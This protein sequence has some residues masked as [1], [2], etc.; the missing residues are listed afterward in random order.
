MKLFAEYTILIFTFLVIFFLGRLFIAW[1]LSVSVSKNK[2][3]SLAK[4]QTF[5]EWL[6]YK[7]Y[8][9][10]LPLVIRMGYFFNF[11]FF[12]ASVICVLV[13]YIMQRPELWNKT[14]GVYFYTNVMFLIVLFFAGEAKEQK[15]KKLKKKK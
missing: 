5:L 15:K 2:R 14:F 6:L 8:A 10:V 1:Y 12:L 9:D 13:F 3:K 4:E 7:R 11:V